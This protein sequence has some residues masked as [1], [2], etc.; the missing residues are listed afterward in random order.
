MREGGEAHII[1][2]IDW[3]RGGICTLDAE[4]SLLITAYWHFGIFRN[5]QE[6]R[7]ID[8]FIKKQSQN[9]LGHKEKKK[10]ETLTETGKKS[11]E[12][13]EKQRNILQTG[14]EEHSDMQ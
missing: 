10:T 9:R 1:K 11:D 6:S 4:R 13:K 2:I 8:R 7:E 14:R 5:E 3:A 12:Q